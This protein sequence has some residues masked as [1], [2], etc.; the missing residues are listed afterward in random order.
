MWINFAES[1]ILPPS[2][3]W[4]FPCLGIMQFN[5]QNTE[6]A[7]EDIKHV[8]KVLDD[9]LLTSTYLVGEHITQADISVCIYTLCTK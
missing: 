8:L 1:E 5:K 3:T 6:K 7:K 9:H 4:T 2:C